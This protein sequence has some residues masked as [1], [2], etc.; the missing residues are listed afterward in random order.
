[1]ST[2]GDRFS[3][4]DAAYVLGALS[5]EDRREFEEH[6]AGC[7]ACQV[8]IA[9]LAGMPGLLAAVAPEDAAMWSVAP[10]PGAD[11]TPPD[12]LLP[13]M[14][15]EIRSRRRRAMTALVAAAAA[16]VLVL[17]GFGLGRVLPADSGPGRVAFSPVEPSSMTALADL[18]PV[19]NGTDIRLECQYGEYSDPT[20]GAAYAKYAIYVV[21]RKGQAEDVKSWTA[22]P[23]KVMRPQGHTALS[24]TKI[25]RIEIRRIDTGQTVLQA[26]LH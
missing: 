3:T 18:V 16:V 14:I 12:T 23:N 11:N 25:K 5:P 19:G 4:W 20:S 21:D 26:A 9:E 1:V 24:V 8:A 7:S 6:L 2:V 22:K 17:G 13:K 10:V 15:T